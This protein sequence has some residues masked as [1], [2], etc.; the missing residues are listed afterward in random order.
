MDM[1]VDQLALL[2]SIAALIVAVIALISGN[3]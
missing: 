1:R 3:N 2:I